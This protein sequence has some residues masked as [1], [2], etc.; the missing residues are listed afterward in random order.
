MPPSILCFV[1]FIL[2]IVIAGVLIW[3]LNAVPNLDADLKAWGRIICIVFVVIVLV[4]TLANCLGV[5]M[6]WNT[7]R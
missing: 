7:L 6:P 2:I 3:G 1:W 5:R 4:L